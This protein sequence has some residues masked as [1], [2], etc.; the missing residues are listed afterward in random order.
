MEGYGRGKYKAELSRFLVYAQASCDET[1][2]HLNLLKDIYAELADE[3]QGYI[4]AYKDLGRK[5]NRFIQYVS[6]DWNKDLARERVPR[7]R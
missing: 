1:V 7:S 5:I 2:L 4:D 3:I 6:K